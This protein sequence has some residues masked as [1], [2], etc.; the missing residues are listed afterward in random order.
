MS[1]QQLPPAI[2]KVDVADR[3]SGK[4]VVRYE[5]RADGGVDPVTGLRRQ[6]KRRYDTEKAARAA[7]AEI[8]DQATTGTFVARSVLTVDQLCT[9][10]LAGRYN[11]RQTSGSKLA[12]DL[13]P[14]RERY[15]SMPM[16]Q[17][18]KAHLDA[19]IGAL[20]RGG[21]ITAKGRTRRAWCCPGAG[22][23]LPSAPGSARS[24]CTPPGTRAR[25]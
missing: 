4:T 16:Q 7:L 5:L 18:T 25:R 24:N 15:G 2:H 8:T 22:A 19:L 13:S 21:T 17:L 9:D 20:V 14:L 11:L 23:K 3:R 10:F 6:V 1:R 12:Y